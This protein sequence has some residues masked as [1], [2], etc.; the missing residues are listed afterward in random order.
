VSEYQVRVRVE[1]G[2]PDLTGVLQRAA[3]AALERQRALPGAL[4][5]VLTGNR[6]IRDLNRRFLGEDH[7][8]DVLAFPDHDVDPDLGGTYFGDIIISLPQAQDGA[9]VAG[10]PLRAELALLAVHGVLHLMGYDHAEPA[11]LREMKREQ[12]AILRSLGF[13][14]LA[15]EHA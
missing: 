12:A 6:Q 7:P 1:T 9:Q 3:R 8:T 13:G 15:W 4:T 2:D 14:A 10:H 11:A 5:I